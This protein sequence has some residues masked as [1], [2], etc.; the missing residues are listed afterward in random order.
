MAEICGSQA[1]RLASTDRPATVH[2]RDMV[3]ADGVVLDPEW[4][5]QRF[6]ALQDLVK[7]ACRTERMMPSPR[8]GWVDA[9]LWRSA[10]PDNEFRLRPSPVAISH[11]DRTFELMREAVDGEKA[12]RIIWLFGNGLKPREVAVKIGLKP[13][14]CRR[15]EK[16]ELYQMW[17]M[18]KEK[19]QKGL[20]AFTG[21]V[22]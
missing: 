9:A 10:Q 17:V 16:R 6:E 5:A 19:T 21:F 18:A 1:S 15:I 4:T 11:M 14:Y 7:Q 13:D 2:G 22:V 12:R 3:R 20:T 8:V